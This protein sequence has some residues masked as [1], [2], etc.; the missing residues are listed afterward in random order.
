MARP[1]Y[2]K[3]DWTILITALVLVALSLLTVYSASVSRERVQNTSGEVLIEQATEVVWKQVAW[4]GIGFL[5]VVIVA[6]IDYRILSG[7][8]YP[9]YFGLILVL[10]AVLFVGE[11][12]MGAT[13]WIRIGAFQFQP[14]ELAKIVMILV[15]ARYF[16]EKKKDTVFLSDIIISAILL[17][18][19]VVLIFREPDLGMTVLLLPVFASIIFVAGIDVKYI[20]GLVVAGL[21]A[22]PLVWLNLKP[23][24][25][26]RLI[27]FINPDSDPL[28]AG[29]HV[30]Q[31][32]I[33]IG[34]GG[35]WGKGYMNGTQSQLKFLPEQMTDF[36]FSVFSEEWG[37]VGSC[38][39]LL[40]YL[41][42]IL[43]GLNIAAKS[44]DK[45]GCLI[46]VGVVSVL[47]AQMF[48]NI[49]VTTG[50]LPAK[51]LTLPW[52]SYGGSSIFSIAIALGLLQNVSY[53]RFD[54]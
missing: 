51:G 23:Y 46:A 31:S 18:V 4:F 41:I 37:F 54:F 44:R 6:S 5:I 12:N 25:R 9:A 20:T 7:L 11:T 34:S 29:Y 22:L 53:R 38:V 13:R 21:A 10:A 42:L 33:A 27:S 15:F 19:P 30:I 36:I 39:L 32:K 8:A 24:H 17:S 49:G 45:L 2:D 14:S 52:M 43:K 48:V 35:F 3:V 47:L 50:L 28:G 16:S 40:A 1:F 26:V